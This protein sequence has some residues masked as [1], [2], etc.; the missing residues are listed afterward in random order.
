MSSQP[1]DPTHR[2]FAALSPVVEALYRQAGGP[3]QLD[4]KFPVLFR[5]AIDEV[6]DTARSNRFVLADLEK[7]EKTYL[8][9]KMEILVRNLLKFPKGQILDLSVDGIEVDIKNTMGRN[10]TIPLE[11]QGHIALLLRSDEVRA[12]CDVGLV[13]VRPDY[14]NPGQNRDQ[15]RT[16]SAQSLGN[17]WWLI[18]AAPYPRNFWQALDLAD[19]EAILRVGSAS[20]RIA[21]LF[22]KLP[23]RPIHRLQIEGLAQQRD[24]MKRIRANGGAR[25]LLRPLGMAILSGLYDHAAIEALGLGP[26]STEEFISVCPV[27][28]EALAILRG[29]GH[30]D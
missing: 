24:Y 28:G 29:A 27:S 18:K 20:R 13:R 5:T 19:R 22:S 21:A 3:D 14:L 15:K 11:C 17:I 30:L 16:L 26:V 8:G 25:D 7:T 12:V 23:G 2:D 9:T 4:Q 10:W 1:L 6:I